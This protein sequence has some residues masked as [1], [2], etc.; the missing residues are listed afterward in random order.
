MWQGRRV[1]VVVMTTATLAVFGLSAPA[2]VAKSTSRWTN[3]QSVT[4]T[5]AQPG[6]PPPGGLP[7]TTQYSSP[8]E[9]HQATAA[10]NTYRIG[11]ARHTRSSKGCVGGRTVRI[12][13]VRS[14]RPDSKTTVRAELCAG[15]QYGKAKGDVAG[16]LT[17]LGLLS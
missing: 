2:A 12:V 6:V 8:E 15:K 16:F 13:I 1:A 17:A 7:K 9:L 14:A 10:L 4:V 3:L 11:V 5:V